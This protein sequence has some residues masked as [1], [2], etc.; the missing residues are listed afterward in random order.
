MISVS[1][2]EQHPQDLVLHGGPHLGPR[3]LL[4]LGDRGGGGAARVP[5]LP[6]PQ[7]QDGEGETS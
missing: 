4:H 5:R 2:C 6:L 1:Q 7:A 3:V